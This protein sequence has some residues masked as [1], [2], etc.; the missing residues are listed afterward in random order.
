MTNLSDI[1]LEFIEKCKPYFQGG[2]SFDGLK[3][4]LVFLGERGGSDLFLKGNGIPS[5]FVYGRLVRLCNEPVGE[6][7]VAAIMTELY[8]TNA[9]ALLGKGT[10]LNPSLAFSKVITVD[11]NGFAVTKDYRFRVNAIRTLWGSEHVTDI[12]IRDIPT[13]PLSV[14]QLNVEPE[15]VRVC[16]NTKIGL[17]LVVGATGS[18]KT[19]LLAALLSNLLMEKNGDRNIITA[20]APIEYVYHKLKPT[21]GRITQIDADRCE[22]SFLGAIRNMLRMTPTTILV[23]ESRDYETISASVNA[24]ETG[25]CVFTTLHANRV[26]DTVA[27]MVAIFPPNLQPEATF[28][29]LDQLSMIVAQVLVPTLDGKRKAAK[30]VLILNKEMRREIL[31]A[32]NVTSGLAAAVE[33]YGK[34]MRND[35]Q[36]LFDSNKISKDVYDKFMGEFG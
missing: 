15:I 13:T 20:E 28:K 35:I 29:I 7:E 21:D 25:H 11:D 22:G 17:I 2:L 33:S 6:N 34:P 30:E 9:K 36:S 31:S 1:S 18:G 4:L 8:G 23:G 24:S 5:A 12:T 26:S 14:E 16:E 32:S 19:T 3:D 10:P 27:R